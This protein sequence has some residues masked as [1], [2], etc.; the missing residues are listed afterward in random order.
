MTNI[1]ASLTLDKLQT[2]KAVCVS[3][4]VRAFVRA[5]VR[6]CVLHACVRDN[7]K[8]HLGIKKFPASSNTLLALYGFQDCTF[9][10]V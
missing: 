1:P 10:R 2:Y 3:E 9:M 6:A 5:C 4:R 7:V 8:E